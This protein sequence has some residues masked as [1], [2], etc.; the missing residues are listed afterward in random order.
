MGIGAGGR[1]AYWWVNGT[2]RMNISTSGAVSIPGSLSKGSGSFQF[3]HPL[4]P[5][6]TDLI[7]SFVEGPRCDLIYR[8]KVKLSGGSA[9]V[10]L[11]LECTGNGKG[12]SPGTFEA[13]CR[14]PQVYLQNNCSFAR[15][16]GHVEGASLSITC[17]DTTAD[18]SIDWMVVA[19]RQDPHIKEWDKTDSE[20]RLILEHPRQVPRKQDD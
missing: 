17:E 3:K 4:R 15:V 8:G 9:K 13:L 6:T 14:D 16:I 11:D 19:E 1:G 10:D 18:C 7:H 20:G 2:D 5:E 12:M